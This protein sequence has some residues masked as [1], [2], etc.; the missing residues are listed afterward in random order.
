MQGEEKAF[1]IGLPLDPNE[2]SAL[3]PNKKN[4]KYIYQPNLIILQG[5]SLGARRKKKKI[6]K[7]FCNFF[8]V[9]I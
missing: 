7:L 6:T 3:S 1:L 9:H 8:R 2:A 4:N 5:F